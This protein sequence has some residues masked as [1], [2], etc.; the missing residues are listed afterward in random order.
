MENISTEEKHI[1]TSSAKKAKINHYRK[2]KIVNP[3]VRGHSQ[4]RHKDQPSDEK[5]HPD[6]LPFK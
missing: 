2:P 6:S 1:I 4:N 3:S 5:F